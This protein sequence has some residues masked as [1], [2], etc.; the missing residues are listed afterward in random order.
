MKTPTPTAAE[1]LLPRKKSQAEEIHPI[2]FL[3][4]EVVL[5]PAF[6]SK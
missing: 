1:L 6:S 5:G 3:T 2:T 4:Q